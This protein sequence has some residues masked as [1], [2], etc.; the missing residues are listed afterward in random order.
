MQNCLIVAHSNLFLACAL[1]IE[2]TQNKPLDLSDTFWSSSRLL[3]QH[4]KLWPLHCAIAIVVDT[5]HNV[6]LLLMVDSQI[7]LDLPDA[8]F[9]ACQGGERG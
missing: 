2:P 7:V 1:R 3:Q 6:E 5:S 9:A 8:H 4:F